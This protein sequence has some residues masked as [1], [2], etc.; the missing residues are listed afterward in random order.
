MA[1]RLYGIDKSLKACVRALSNLLSPS[2]ARPRPEKFQRVSMVI[3]PVILTYSTRSRCVNQFVGDGMLAA[4][5]G[6]RVM[7]KK[8]TM[9]AGALVATV[10]LA[11]SANAAPTIFFGGHAYESVTGNPTDWASAKAAA[12]AMTYNGQSGYLA[13]ITSAAENAALVPFSFPGFTHWLGGSDDGAEGTWSWRTGPETGQIFFVLGAGVQPGYSNWNGGEP[14]NCCGSENHLTFLPNSGLWN[15]LSGSSQIAYLVEF[16]VV[17]EPAVW[18]LMI[19]GFGLV[20][21][22]ARRR[23]SVQLTA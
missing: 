5:G 17:P 16:N 14:N 19:G 23:R 18:A 11:G 8:L 15:D 7:G 22:A 21:V 2:P 20:G 6:A 12:E 9:L 13:T 1:P 3:T 4:S 10:G